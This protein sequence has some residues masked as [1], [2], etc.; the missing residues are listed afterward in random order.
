MSNFTNKLIS[1]L[2]RAVQIRKVCTK[3]EWSKARADFHLETAED[4]LKRAIAELEQQL[5]DLY[6]IGGLD[7]LETW[8]VEKAQYMKHISELENENLELKKI[9]DGLCKRIIKL[10]SALRQI[11]ILYRSGNGHYKSAQIAEKA[12]LNDE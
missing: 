11:A 12:L 7:V 10:E 6:P 5:N 9:N 1:D 3:N 4:D 2:V 8:Q